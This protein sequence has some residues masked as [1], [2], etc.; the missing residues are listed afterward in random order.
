MKNV[1]LPSTPH[2]GERVI[3]SVPC[4]VVATGKH[5]AIIS[6]RNPTAGF[7]SISERADKDVLKGESWTFEY[8]GHLEAWVAWPTVR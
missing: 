7:R 5:A 6:R 4:T 8:F 1:L 3:Y 2:H